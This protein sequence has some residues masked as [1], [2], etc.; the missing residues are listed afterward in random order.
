MALDPGVEVDDPLTARNVEQA[1]ARLDSA[2]GVEAQSTHP[3]A[4]AEPAL[5][6][7]GDA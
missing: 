2:Q 4:E 1:L 6:E 3:D 7:A 5:Q